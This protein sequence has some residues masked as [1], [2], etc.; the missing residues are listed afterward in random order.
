MQCPKCGARTEVIEKRGAFRDRRCLKAECRVEFTTRE[1]IM[2]PLKPIARPGE[3]GR[4]CA[5]TR[6]TQIERTATRAAGSGPGTPQ[7]IG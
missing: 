3:H 5:R 7:S 4:L 6:V 2:R 1:Q